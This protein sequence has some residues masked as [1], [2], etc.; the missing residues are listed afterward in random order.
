[1]LYAEP[2][3]IAQRAAREARTL[4]DALA[5]LRE[6]PLDDFGLLLLNPSEYGLGSLLPRM[7]PDAVQIRWTGSAGQTL[8]AQSLTFMRALES[9]HAR[10]RERG[11]SGRTL[12]DYGCGWG[13]LMRLALYYSD[14]ERIVGVDAWDDSLKH[15]R[16]HG[17]PG[18]LL[19]IDAAPDALPPMPEID[20]AYAFSIFTHLPESTMRAALDAIGARTARNGLLIFTFRPIEYWDHHQQ[21]ELSTRTDLKAAH[22][23]NGFAYQPKGDPDSLYGDTSMSNAFVTRILQETGWRA[24]G[25]DRAIADTFQPIVAAERI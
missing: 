23:A 4:N 19:K 22:N 1:M 12:L 13:R 11:L 3:S 18:T 21:F 9:I 7:P 15:S 14:P 20:V 5:I 25:F 6:M 16:E 2:A 10:F 8:L 17:V 24:L